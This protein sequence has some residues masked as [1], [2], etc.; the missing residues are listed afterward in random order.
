MAVWDVAC[1]KR[2]SCAVNW[3]YDITEPLSYRYDNFCLYQRISYVLYGGKWYRKEVVGCGNSND[4]GHD[5]L[6]IN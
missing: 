3:V 1:P 2:D 4:R 5:P 6:D